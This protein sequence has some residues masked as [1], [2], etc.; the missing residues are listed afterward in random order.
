MSR[1]LTFKSEPPIYPRCS[2]LHSGGGEDA[3][4][5]TMEIELDKA[6]SQP[7]EDGNP[8][9]NTVVTPRVRMHELLQRPF[10]VR[11]IAFNGLFLL[12]VFYTIY[13]VR[14]L[15]LPLV[16]ALLLSYLL[17]PIVRGLEKLKI[18]PLIGGALLLISLFG[19]FGY[20]A[21]FLAAPAASWID[22]AP[23]SLRHL[24]ERLTPF[25][26]PIAQV[27]QASGAI[28]KLTTTETGPAKTPTVEVKQHPIT[29]RLFANTS[30]LLV[31]TLTV[32]ILLYFLLAYHE[33]FLAK[34]IKLMP[35][36]SDKKR[37]VT[38]A[39]EIEAQISRYLFTITLINLC[40]GIAVGTTVGFLGL[41]NPV[42][43]GVL[44]ALLNFIPYLGALTGIFCMLLG[45]LLSFDSLGFALIFPAAYLALS[46]IVGN[47]ITPF[48]MGRSLT[49]NPVLVLLSLMFWGWMWGIVGILLAVPILA[50]FKI[51]CTH[52]KPME[53]L[54]EFMS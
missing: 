43:W 54:A 18:P 13:F 44:V 36:L 4:I 11:S 27:A 35:T 42:M 15:L 22:K 33:V 49:L 47:F 8:T 16:L 20:S 32:I 12:A 23:Y 46:T 28:E 2:R 7:A 34:L 9:E 25:K 40:L 26:K 39:H 41:S 14:S 17:R 3:F 5:D 48:V 10:S 24:Q 19:A 37:A 45:A 50:T 51:F 38:I 29:D 31:S 52:L 53:P 30:E 21:S 1:D 6:T